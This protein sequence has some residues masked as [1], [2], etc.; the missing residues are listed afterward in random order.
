MSARAMADRIRALPEA[1]RAKVYAMLREDPAAAR[2]LAFEWERFWARPDQV[3]TQDERE[4]AA[5]IVFTGPRRAGKSLGAIQYWT[6]EILEGRSEWPRI[7]V[8]SEADVVGTVLDGPSGIR[9]W[10]PR[11]CWP[12]HRAQSDDGPA[13]ELVFPNRVKVRCFAATSPGRPRGR[14]GDLDLYDDVAAWAPD[15]SAEELWKNARVSCAEPRPGLGTAQGV[16]AT[17]RR[18]TRLIEN[19]LRGTS[20]RVVIKRP[21]DA[22]ANAANLAIGYHAQADAELSELDED[23]AAEELEDQ[24][25]SARSPFDGISFRALRTTVE[26]SDLD[27]VVIAVDPADGKGGAHDEWGIVAMARRRSDRHLVVLEDRSGSYDD[28]EAGEAAIELLERWRGS[29]VIAETNRGPRVVS[30]LRA[31]FLAREVRALR[32]GRGG[33]RGEPRFIGVNATENKRLRA[34]PVVNLYRSGLVHHV[35]GL[36]KLEAQM[37]GWDPDAPKRPRTDD[38]IDAA[39]HGATYLAGLGVGAPAIRSSAERSRDAEGIIAAQASF[40]APTWSLDRV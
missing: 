23:W 8:A 18:G 9:R 12:A 28:R 24:E 31:G 16:V 11:E 20:A 25:R 19:L 39:V 27:E 30:L 36:S 2:W 10:F 15:K 21:P 40:A 33:L 32:E 7:F 3:V 38:R 6:R 34:G 37:A 14:G 5:L 26:I 22:R 1:D 13:G 29:A 17:T 4:G 35:E